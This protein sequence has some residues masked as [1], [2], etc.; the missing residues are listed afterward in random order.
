VRL[1]G[2]G[3]LKKPVISSG[4][5]AARSVDAEENVTL[6]E[7]DNQ[8]N[9]WSYL[10]PR[11]VKGSLILSVALLG[12]CRRRPALETVGFELMHMLLQACHTS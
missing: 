2:L 4:I 8:R 12:S 6:V 1:E 11:D 10:Y 5:E 7:I 9:R 3:Q